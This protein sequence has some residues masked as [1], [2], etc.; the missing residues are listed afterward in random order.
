MITL[1]IDNSEIEDIFIKG[2]QSNKER[3][4]EFIKESYL[5]RETI[6]NY[7]AN[8]EYFHN[9]YNDIQNGTMPLYSEDEANKIVEKYIKYI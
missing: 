3:F 9:I 7:Q 1:Q 5:H 8:K 4:L 6:K 2:F